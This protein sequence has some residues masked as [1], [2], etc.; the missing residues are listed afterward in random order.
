MIKKYIL[1]LERFPQRDFIERV[2]FGFDETTAVKSILDKY[3]KQNKTQ[4][5]RLA[6]CIEIID[7]R[8]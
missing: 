7:T 1:K 3:F 2:G 5:I 6:G 8:A 4:K